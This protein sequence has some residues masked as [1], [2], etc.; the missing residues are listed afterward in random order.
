M[1]KFNRKY[2]SKN[3]NKTQKTTAKGTSASTTSSPP[4][5][6]ELAMEEGNR[7]LRALEEEREAYEMMLRKIEAMEEAHEMENQQKILQLEEMRETWKNHPRLY[8]LTSEVQMQLAETQKVRGQV[9]EER[10]IEMSKKRA[11]WSEQEDEIYKNMRRE[12][13]DGHQEN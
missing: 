2:K 13:E 3:S 8:A 4:T 1:V 11:S 9:K 7:K 12:I 6:Q 5:R 10:L